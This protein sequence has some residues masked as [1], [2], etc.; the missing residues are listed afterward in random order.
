MYVYTCM[1]VCI[2]YVYNIYIYIYMVDVLHSFVG[3]PKLIGI[4]VDACPGRPN[5]GFLFVKRE[6]VLYGQCNELCGVYRGFMP[7]YR[8]TSC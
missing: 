7:A 4:K 2:M 1:Y 6:G 3:C 8:T 5:Q